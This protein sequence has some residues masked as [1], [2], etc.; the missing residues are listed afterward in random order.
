MRVR[1]PRDGEPEEGWIV[2]ATILSASRLFAGTYHLSD[3][4]VRM[5][6]DEPIGDVDVQAE[7][8]ASP[9]RLVG[10]GPMPLPH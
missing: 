1:A 4:A 5:I 2:D 9:F 8:W 6:G 10:T 7:R 3:G